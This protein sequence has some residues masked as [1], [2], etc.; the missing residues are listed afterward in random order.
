MLLVHGRGAN[1]G[2][3]LS[4]ADEL[5]GDDLFDPRSSMG[6]TYLAPQAV[7]STWYP[8]RFLA[9]LEQNEP[10][11]SSALSAI[12]RV[13]RSIQSAGIPNERIMVLGFSQGA[14]LALEYAARRAR[15]YGG[16]VGLS[17][18]LIGPSLQPERYPGSLSG[19]PVFLGCSDI[20]PHI[21]LQ[22]VKESAAHLEKMGADVSARI[23]PGMGHTVNDEELDIV[24]KMMANNIIQNHP[25]NPGN[26][27]SVNCIPW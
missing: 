8:Q 14:C 12:D 19:T 18:G 2:D 11:L 16:V 21:P 25:K 10:W 6:F 17:G 3:I 13:I 20:D 24:R 23:Y 27:A 5:D 26:L 4:L 1:A 7:G 15:R 22:R 9:P